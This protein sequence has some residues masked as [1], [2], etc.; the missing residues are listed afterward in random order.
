MSNTVLAWLD[1]GVYSLVLVLIGVVFWIVLRR[2]CVPFQAR[3]RERAREH[4]WKCFL[5]F[6]AAM[7]EVARS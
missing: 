2:P 1:A 5:A 6:L 4:A 3:E 7:W